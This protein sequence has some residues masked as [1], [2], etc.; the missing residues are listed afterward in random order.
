MYEMELQLW[1]YQTRLNRDRNDVQV[2]CQPN[3]PSELKKEL[4]NDKVETTGMANEV[5]NEE[6]PLPKFGPCPNMRK[7]YIFEDEMKQL[8]SR[9]NL[10]DSP[11]TKEQ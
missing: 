7:S 3:P 9:F 10:N 2:K 5:K 4:T 8:T 11:F 1:H 6:A